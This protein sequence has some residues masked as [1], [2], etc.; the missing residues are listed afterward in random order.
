MRGVEGGD[1]PVLVVEEQN[2]DWLSISKLDARQSWPGEITRVT[3]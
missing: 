1:Q 3:R 2:Y